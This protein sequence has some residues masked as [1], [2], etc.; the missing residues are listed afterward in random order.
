MVA[1]Q[2]PR[3]SDADPDQRVLFHGV[4]WA[5]F[6]LFLTV[7]GDQ[8]GPRMAFLDGK[9]EIMSPS[10]SHEEIK[11]RLARLLESFALERDLDLRGFGSWTLRS[12]LE[13]KG[14]EPDECYVI[15]ERH[16]VP[17]LAVEVVWT[18]GG[19]DKL[20]IYRALRVPEVWRWE[21]GAIQ[22]FV[23]RAGKYKQVKQPVVLRG[24]D[25]NLLLRFL[26]EPSQTRAVK[27]F[28]K[29]LRQG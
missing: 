5:L 1:L 24:L 8:A 28:V 4:T 20:E 27:G 18:S 15:G 6:E 14:L 2:L 12:S 3:S 21:K 23:L 11:K 26:D 13:E 9:M 29:A 25:V 10:P 19:V 17:D 16:D 7:R 22:I